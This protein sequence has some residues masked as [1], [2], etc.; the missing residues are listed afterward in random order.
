MLLASLAIKESG[1][2]HENIVLAILAV[3]ITADIFEFPPEERLFIEAASYRSE[4]KGYSSIFR[5]IE[6]L[7][8][9]H[10]IFDINLG[11]VTW[12]IFDEA[13][14]TWQEIDN[15]GFTFDEIGNLTPEELIF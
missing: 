2:S 12:E 13:E 1:F 8:P 6:Q 3:G 11:L 4:L 15:K 5:R 10:L 14:H 9:A 7:L